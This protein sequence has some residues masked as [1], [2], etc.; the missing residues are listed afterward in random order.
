VNI[1]FLILFSFFVL[2]KITHDVLAPKIVRGTVASL[3]KLSAVITEKAVKREQRVR[4]PGDGC[5]HT[6]LVEGPTEIY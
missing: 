4:A 5:H 3:S 6:K 2:F 1:N